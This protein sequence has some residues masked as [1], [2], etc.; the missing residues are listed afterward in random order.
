MNISAI[1]FIVSFAGALVLHEMGHFLAAR[2]CQVAVTQA[3]F[4]WGPKLFGFRVKGVDYQLRLLPIGAYIR[5]GHVGFAKAAVIPTI[6]RA[7]RR[8][9]SESHSRRH[10]LGNVLRYSQSSAGGRESVPVL[11]TRRMEERDGDLPSRL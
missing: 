10:R 7:A 2:T 1:N 5:I 6:V 9:Y 11:S 3:G 4:G 8:H